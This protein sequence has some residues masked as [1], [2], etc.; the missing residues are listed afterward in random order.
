M[1]VEKNKRPTLH[2]NHPY[3]NTEWRHR[4]CEE[5]HWE[6]E[7]WMY[8]PVVTI[9]KRHRKKYASHDRALAAGLKVA[10]AFRLEPEVV[11]YCKP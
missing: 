7:I 9:A 5:R 10:E 8:K 2:I 3:T 11:C 6:W 1:A 4:N